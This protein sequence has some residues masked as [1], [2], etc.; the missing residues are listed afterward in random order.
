[1]TSA[2]QF[3]FLDCNKNSL[4]NIKLKAPDPGLGLYA[5]NIA[6]DWAPPHIE[7]TSSKYMLQ[8]YA[9]THNPSYTRLG[10]NTEELS[11]C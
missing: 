11:K 3:S 4:N 6:E 5:A 9:K 1:M 7:P 10:N 8:F 2:L